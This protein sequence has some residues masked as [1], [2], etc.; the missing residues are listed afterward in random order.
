MINHFTDTIIIKQHFL[1]NITIISQKQK[2]RKMREGSF[3]YNLF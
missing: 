1:K 2:T 3:F